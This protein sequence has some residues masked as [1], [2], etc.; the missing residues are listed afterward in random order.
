VT[1]RSTRDAHI[2]GRKRRA[3]PLPW[4]ESEAGIWQDRSDRPAQCPP[5]TAR[6]LRTASNFAVGSTIPKAQLAFN[7]ICSKL[8]ATRNGFG[9]AAR[10]PAGGNRE[11]PVLRRSLF[12]PDHEFA[13]KTQVKRIFENTPTRYATGLV[14]R[15]DWLR[16]VN[17]SP[18]RLPAAGQHRERDG[19][20]RNFSRRNPDPANACAASD[21]Q[22]ASA[23]SQL[24]G[25]A[26]ATHS[27]SAESPLRGPISPIQTTVP[28]GK[29]RGL[30]WS[31]APPDYLQWMITKTDMDPDVLWNA[32]REINNRARC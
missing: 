22:G 16:A 19:D 9:R 1:L 21:W 6:G 15:H 29:H 31:K 13:W 30:P 8:N 25:A 27:R 2:S 18:D 32:Q 4:H 5:G 10:A 24:A 3:C 28:F 26:G 20:R 11:V 7:R 14:E 23:L 17:E 12:N